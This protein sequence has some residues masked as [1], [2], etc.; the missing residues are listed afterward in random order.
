MSIRI[1]IS[2]LI[3]FAGSGLGLIVQILIARNYGAS[4]EVDAYFASISLPLFLSG[5]ITSAYMFG[6]VPRIIELK[7]SINK[8]VFINSLILCSLMIA[9]LFMMAIP[10]VGYQIDLINNPNIKFFNHIQMLYIL[11]W[12]IGS[13][14]ILYGSCAAML[15]ANERYYSCS[16]SALFPYIGVILGIGLYK[17]ILSIPL[18]IGRAHV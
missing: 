8:P 11:A 5:L 9:A 1:I 15:T 18:E 12:F 16:I 14:Q 17:N 13:A 3:S 4:I 6:V 7:H 2:T 10:F